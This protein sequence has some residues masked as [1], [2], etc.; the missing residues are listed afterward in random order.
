MKKISTVA[1][2]VTLFPLLG[3][4]SEKQRVA[5][6][7]TAIREIVPMMGQL[8]RCRANTILEQGCAKYHLVFNAEG[9]LERVSITE[10]DFSNEA[11][12]SAVADLFRAHVSVSPTK[13]EAKNL[14]V[15]APICFEDQSPVHEDFQPYLDKKRNGVTN[16]DWLAS[17]INKEA[18]L[19]NCVVKDKAVLPRAETMKP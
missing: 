4:A 2:L 7:D 14:D 8:Y 16:R 10:S 19:R 13:E 11:F 15:H 5:E 18:E 17:L 12:F 9:K 1:V 3:Q 6:A